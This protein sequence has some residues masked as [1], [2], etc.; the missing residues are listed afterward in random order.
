MNQ[1]NAAPVAKEELRALV[2]EEWQN[3][4]REEL[5]DDAPATIGDIRQ[6]VRE[7]VRENPPAPAASP[8][9]ALSETD[10]DAIARRIIQITGKSGK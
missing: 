2:C 10:I 3:I 8:A 6:M 1:E 4:L 9:P 7:A 5:G